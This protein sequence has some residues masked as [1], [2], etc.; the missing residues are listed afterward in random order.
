M[1]KEKEPEA[2]IEAMEAQIRQRDKSARDLKAQAAAID[3]A[4][5]DLKAVHPNAVAE[6]DGH[7]PAQIIQIIQDQGQIVAEAL[8]RLNA[9]MQN[10]AN[11]EK[12][13]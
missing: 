11:E 1:K 2:K 10:P 13:A 6:V 5:F 9:L 7:T 12:A 4:V 3:A 8:A